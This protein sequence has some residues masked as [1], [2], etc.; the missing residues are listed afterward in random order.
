MLSLV[1][2]EFKVLF[3]SKVPSN[4]DKS[5]Q[6]KIDSAVNKFRKYGSTLEDRGYAVRQLADCLEFLKS[7][8][9]VKLSKK[10]DSDIFNIANNFAVRHHNDKQKNNYNKNIWLSWMFYFYLATIHAVVRFTE[11]KEK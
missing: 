11:E 10:D 7:E 2:E 5:I 1:K 3:E 6:E 9:K 4:I 8:I